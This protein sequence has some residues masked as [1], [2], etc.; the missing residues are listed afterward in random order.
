MIPK[1]TQMSQLLHHMVP[2]NPIVKGECVGHVQKRVGGRLRKLKN[3]HGSELLS[4]GKKLG[5]VGR[6]HDRWI[7]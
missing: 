4:D 7:N 5:G 3:E 1:H 6:L 2:D